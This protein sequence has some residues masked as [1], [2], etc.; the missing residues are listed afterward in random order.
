MLRTMFAL[1]AAV[2]S[3]S[4]GPALAHA[5][6]K[7]SL[8]I[9]AHAAAEAE[10]RK[11][12]REEID[13]MTESLLDR[14]FRKAVIARLRTLDQDKKAPVMGMLPGFSRSIDSLE[15]LEDPWIPDE[16]RIRSAAKALGVKL[17]YR[18]FPMMEKK[19]PPSYGAIHRLVSSIWRQHV[20]SDESG[21]TIRFDLPDARGGMFR[22]SRSIFDGSGEDVFTRVSQQKKIAG[23]EPWGARWMVIAAALE[24]RKIVR[25][26]RSERI[27]LLV[28]CNP[29]ADSRS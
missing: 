1:A 20:M 19:I 4:A 24:Y 10:V 5:S 16:H 6:P 21:E 28:V 29:K 23:V 7:C 26:W 11:Y 2:A 8:A 9:G 17:T 25:R 3:M 18:H 15:E 13:R 12:P 27:K 22:G 14:I